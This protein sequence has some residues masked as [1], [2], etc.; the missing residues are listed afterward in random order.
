VEILGPPQGLY[1]VV[2]TGLKLGPYALAIRPFSQNGSSEPMVALL[3]IAGPGTTATFQLQLA[4]IP[5]GTSQL[6]LVASFQGTLGDI[7]NSVQLGLLDNQGIA[8]SLAQKILNAQSA[9]T[10]GD[11]KTA[12]N[13]LG[14]FK[15]ELTAQTG[16]HV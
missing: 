12:I 15:N 1:Q 5:G 8:N 4:T 14:A 16:K 3:G 7:A 6:N 10:E 2:V 11:R 13:V 9:A